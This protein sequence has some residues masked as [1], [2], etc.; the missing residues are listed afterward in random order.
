MSEERRK[1]DE[2]VLV[3]ITKLSSH[4]E[5]DGIIPTIKTQVEKT[6][7]RVTVL[8]KFMWTMGGGLIIISMILGVPKALQVFSPEPAVAEVSESELRLLI[9]EILDEEIKL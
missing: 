1:N 7:G 6:N 4:F 2:E 5:K 3:A 9:T 8:E